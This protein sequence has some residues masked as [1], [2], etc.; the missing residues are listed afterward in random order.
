MSIPSWGHS[1]SQARYSWSPGLAQGAESRQVPHLKS[2]RSISYCCCCSLISHAGRT[3]LVNQLT[4]SHAPSQTHHI[5]R[6]LGRHPCR[7]SS[8]TSSCWRS[9]AGSAR[10]HPRPPHFAGRWGTRERMGMYEHPPGCRAPE[11]RIRASS[12]TRHRC[13]SPRE[14]RERALTNGS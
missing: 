14:R 11:C 7:L 4:C 12:R 2:E 8:Y 9:G 5:E 6:M 1:R 13:C 10:A 3:V